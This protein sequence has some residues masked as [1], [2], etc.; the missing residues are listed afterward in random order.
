VLL[1]TVVVILATLA[2]VAWTVARGRKVDLMLWVS[3]ALVVVLGGATIWFHSETFIKWKPSVLYWVMGMSL[4]LSQ[5]LF[6][7]NLLRLLLGE[8]L[9]LPDAV[10]QRLNGAWVGFFGV[11]GLLN[12]WVAYSFSTDAWVNFKLFGGIGLML[13]FTLAQ[14]LYLSRYLPEEAPAPKD[15]ARPGA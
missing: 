9:Q 3:L 11:M 10:W 2:Q 6:R 7:K 13:L 4:W 8:Q 5:L 12:L 14:G 1:A 15:K